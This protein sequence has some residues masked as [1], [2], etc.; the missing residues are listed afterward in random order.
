MALVKLSRLN[1]S[2]PI[3]MGRAAVRAL[4]VG[5]R[6]RMWNSWRVDRGGGEVSKQRMRVVRI[7]YISCMYEILRLQM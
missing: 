4:R 3:S 2:K 7:Y 1:K 6:Y 5:R